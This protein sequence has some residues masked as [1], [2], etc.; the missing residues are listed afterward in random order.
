MVPRP[1][2]PRPPR[3][4][5]PRGAPEPV[6]T[7]RGA[8][9][10][11]PPGPRRRAVL[12]VLQ[13]HPACGEPTA[14]RLWACLGCEQERGLPLEAVAPRADWGAGRVDLDRFPE[15]LQQMPA[16]HHLYRLWSALASPQRRMRR[17]GRARRPSP[18]DA[19]AA[20]W[21]RSPLSDRPEARPGS[22]ARDRRRWCHSGALCG[23]PSRRCRS[24]AERA[25]LRA[26]RPF[27]QSI[28]TCL[29]TGGYAS[30]IVR[31]SACLPPHHH[32]YS[33]SIWMER[34]RGR[35]WI[36]NTCWRISRGPSTKNSC[37][38]MSTW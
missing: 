28:R 30:T 11:G 38:A 6:R 12:E 8:G 15:I 22:R 35:R 29:S 18:R 23:T 4:S 1:A 5:L 2:G 3:G 26:G 31:A 20:T 10:V 32:P 24:H 34:L 25:P 13:G 33:V 9:P 14:P 37:C 7:A 17:R 19:P 16:V 27:S 36:G 21:R